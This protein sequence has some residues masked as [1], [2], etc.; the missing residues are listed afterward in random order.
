MRLTAVVALMIWLLAGWSIAPALAFGPDCHAGAGS[1]AMTTPSHMAGTE[2][3]TMPAGMDM[4][5]HPG[6][7]GSRETPGKDSGHKAM[8]CAVHCLGLGTSLALAP[9]DIAQNLS[10]AMAVSLPPDSRLLGRV[11]GPPLE[12]PIAAFA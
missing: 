1:A 3:M 2:G 8:A 5:H 12:P 6:D 4:L 7:D 11:P 9:H 10:P